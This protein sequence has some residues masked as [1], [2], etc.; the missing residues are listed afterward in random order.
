MVTNG[1]KYRALNNSDFF[2]A[3]GAIEFCGIKI[4]YNSKDLSI[5]SLYKLPQAC[6]SSADWHHFLSQFDG[7]FLIGEDF[8]AHN[9]AWGYPSTCPKGQKDLEIYLSLDLHILND[10][11]LTR[12]GTP[13]SQGLA[14][15]LSITNCSSLV[16]PH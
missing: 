1:V 9:K 10:E 6:L 2:N 15:D 5:F 4:A 3:N 8:N 7:D 16:T 14:I 13:H 12:F 11:S